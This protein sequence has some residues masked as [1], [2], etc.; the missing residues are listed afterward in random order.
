MNSPQLPWI[1][2]VAGKPSGS[3]SEPLLRQAQSLTAIAKAC[4]LIVDGY[5]EVWRDLSQRFWQSNVFA[6][7][8]SNPI[9]EGVKTVLITLMER[10]PTAGAVLIPINHCAVEESSWLAATQGAVSL[11]VDNP[12]TVYMLHDNPDNDPRIALIRPDICS[13][14]VMV[15]SARALLDLCY[16]KRATA[17][18]DLTVKD[19]TGNGDPSTV[20]DRHDDAPLN[21]VHVR[22]VEEYAQLQRFDAAR[23]RSGVVDVH[24]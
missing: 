15:G 9:I 1:R 8:R 17:I 22:L 16:G 10:E 14:S 4:C 23:R 12:D 13:S 20:A 18:V 19:S 7:E 24:A 5:Q 21:V 2:F 11:G 3:Y 6:S